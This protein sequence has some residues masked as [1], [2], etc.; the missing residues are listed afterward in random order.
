MFK[1]LG[2]GWQQPNFSVENDHRF[3]TF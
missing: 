1:G 2:R 3:I